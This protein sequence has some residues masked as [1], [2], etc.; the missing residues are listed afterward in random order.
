METKNA[1]ITCAE[2]FIEDHGILTAFLYLDYGGESQG[3]G[4]Y[5]LQSNSW[6]NDTPNRAGMFIRRTLE[7]V[8]VDNWKNL[9]GKTI[10]VKADHT[11]VHSIGHIIKDNWFTPQEEF[12]RLLNTGIGK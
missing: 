11:K 4:G 9:P 8:G 7:V 6:P 1:V 3:F 10:R 2:I 5:G 12:E